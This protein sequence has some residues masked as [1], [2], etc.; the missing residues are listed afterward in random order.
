M[1]PKTFCEFVISLKN[2]HDQYHRLQNINFMYIEKVAMENQCY[3]RRISQKD[4]NKIMEL[5]IHEFAHTMCNHVTWRDGDHGSDFKNAEK[6][7][8]DCYKKIKT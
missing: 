2:C 3:V 8:W 4:F 6:I 7:L 1:D 5:V